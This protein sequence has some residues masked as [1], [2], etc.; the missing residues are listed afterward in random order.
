[1]N[2][3]NIEFLA[4]LD[5]DAI[6]MVIFVDLVLS[7]DNAIIIGMAAASLPPTLRRK[8]I[9]WGIGLAVVLR[10]V[11]AALTFYL[12]QLHGIKFIGALLLLGVCYFMWKDLKISSADQTNTG[13]PEEDAQEDQMNGSESVSLMSPEFSRAMLKIIVADVT[14]SLDNVLAVA[15][16]AHDNIGVLIFGLVL[17]I[18]LMAIGANLVSRLLQKHHWLGYIG[19]LII[20]YVALEMGYYGGIEVLELLSIRL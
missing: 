5:I 15:G 1:M 9:I 12:L 10:I 14:M 16:I 4:G 8:A 19:L 7:G 13:T 18:V 6:L 17:S 2:F 11:L 20:F 3:Q